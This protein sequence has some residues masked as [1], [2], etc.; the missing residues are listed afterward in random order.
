MNTPHLLQYVFYTSLEILLTPPSAERFAISLSNPRTAH[1]LQ[2]YHMYGDAKPIH[3][4][5]K[6]TAMIFLS[7]TVSTRYSKVCATRPPFERIT[8]Y[9]LIPS[10]SICVTLTREL[11][12]STAL[13][14]ASLP[15]GVGAELTK[16]RSSRRGLVDEADILEICP[17]GVMAW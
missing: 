15:P 17:H 7:L 12:V 11:H 8:G 14:P 9:G 5:F 1:H 2:L 10:A 6:S 13:R 4:R 3:S 16:M